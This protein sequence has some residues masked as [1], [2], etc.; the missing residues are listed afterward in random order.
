MTGGIN[1]EVRRRCGWE[2]R[3]GGKTGKVEKVVEHKRWD[4]IVGN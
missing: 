4:G 1:I 2:G 3:L